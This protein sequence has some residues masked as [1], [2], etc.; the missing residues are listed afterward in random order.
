M[1]YRR[2][3]VQAVQG[4]LGLPEGKGN[5]GHVRKER[6][7]AVRVAVAGVAAVGGHGLVL[8][9]LLV[10]EVPHEARAVQVTVGTRVE[11]H[12]PVSVL[13][14]WRSSNAS[15]SQCVSQC[16]SVHQLVDFIHHAIAP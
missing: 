14:T 11:R 3:R 13:A 2:R 7:L 12:R 15:F 8:S 4:E 10:A 1:S 6:S 5:V 16:R 9:A